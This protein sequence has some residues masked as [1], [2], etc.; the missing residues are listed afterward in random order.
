MLSVVIVGYNS[1]EQ[2]RNCLSSLK[3]NVQIPHQI[4]YVDNASKDGSVQWV[5]EQ[6]SE[7]QI[8]ANQKNLG[9][10]AGCNL[11]ISA[12]TEGPVLILNPDIVVKPGSIERLCAALDEDSRIGIIGPA[13]YYPSGERQESCRTVQTPWLILLRRTSLGRLNLWRKTLAAHLAQEPLKP[14]FETDWLLGACM[15]VR[16]EAIAEVGKF[17]ESFF[18]YFED[19]D[20]CYRMWGAGWRVVCDNGAHMIHLHNRES[21]RSS[22][23][24]NRALRLHLHSAIKFFTKY[25]RLIIGK[26]P[27]FLPSF[28][29]KQS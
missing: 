17:D 29:K 10:A 7:I 21:A 20:W 13:L 5:S 18:L 3:Q 12:S 6:Y 2:L 4:I 15:L 14:H 24:P 11:G 9:F 26:T 28:K 8:I 23:L 1:R 19:L 16:R 27:P 25:P 22:I